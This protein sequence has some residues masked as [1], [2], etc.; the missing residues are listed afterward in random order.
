MHAFENTPH[1]GALL[2][3][4]M[5]RV[6]VYLRNGSGAAPPGVQHDSILVP[7][8]QHFILRRKTQFE[9]EENEQ[10]LYRNQPYNF[11][12]ILCKCAVNYFSDLVFRNNDPS[13]TFML[14]VTIIAT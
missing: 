4:W 13:G 2:R 3:H 9:K 14:E 5:S 6:S 10:Q 1:I 7:L 11:L 8:L 12:R